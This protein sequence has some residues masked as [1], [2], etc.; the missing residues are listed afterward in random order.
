MLVDMR[1]IRGHSRIGGNERVDRI[2]K[3]YASNNSARFKLDSNLPAHITQIIWPFGFNLVGLAE[4]L[5]LSR[6]PT[7]P[8]FLVNSMATRP[9]FRESE[10]DSDSKSDSAVECLPRVSQPTQVFF[11]ESSDEDTKHFS[12]SLTLVSVIVAL[13]LV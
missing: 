3:R 10:L 7:P 13:L 9:L 12:A 11:H 8:P 6:L 5:F 2:S 4:E 1:W